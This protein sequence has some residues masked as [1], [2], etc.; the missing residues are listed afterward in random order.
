MWARFCSMSGLA[1]WFGNRPSTSMHIGMI[2]HGSCSK[3]FGATRP[4]MPLPASRTHVKGLIAD[5]S[6]NEKTWPM[7]ASRT[8]RLLRVPGRAAGAGRV[9]F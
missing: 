9:P 2:L 7:Y 4:P 3:I 5:L 1:S 8:L 6:M